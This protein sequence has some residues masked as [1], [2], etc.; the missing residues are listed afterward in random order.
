M[1]VYILNDAGNQAV[2][3]FIRQHHKHPESQRIEPWLDEAD[4]AAGNILEGE[5]G[6]VLEIRS[7]DT[8]SGNTEAIF[9]S[10]QEHLTE[11][12]I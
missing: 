4:E 10:K 8:I 5:S 2:A 9:L 6:C 1:K 7:W 12:E 3:D 11:M